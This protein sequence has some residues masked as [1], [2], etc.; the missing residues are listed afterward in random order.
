MNDSSYD[1]L[2]KLVLAR[3]GTVKPSDSVVN[4]L[5]AWLRAEGGQPA[6]LDAANDLLRK[7][8]RARAVTIFPGDSNTRLL[9]LMAGLGSGYT[10]WDCL[11]TLLLPV[12]P[13]V[14]SGPVVG[15]P[16]GFTVDAVTSDGLT[17]H[18]N[19]PTDDTNVMS[20]RI[21]YDPEMTLFVGTP[22]GLE[23]SAE[24]PPGDLSRTVTGL[25]PST[26]YYVQ[27]I[28][29]GGVD[30][31]VNSEWTTAIEITTLP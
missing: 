8:A 21:A 2:R 30:W 9:Q 20:W 31:E 15:V 17:A 14:P 26:T 3:G 5:Q 18:W 1:L 7:I 16:T 10:K 12:A 22:S 19:L 11:Q 23:G 4:L 29:G 25:L 6:S 13:P 27:L 28:A 24:F